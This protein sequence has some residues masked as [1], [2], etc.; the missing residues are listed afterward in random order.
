MQSKVMDGDVIIHQVPTL[1]NYSDVGTK[2]RPRSRLLFLLCGIV[3]EA[4]TAE[5]LGLEEY[6]NVAEQD[7]K[8]REISKLAKVLKRTTILMTV[9]GLGPVVAEGAES[10]R[11]AICNVP[12]QASRRSSAMSIL[13]CGL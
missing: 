2:S 9:Q 3:V 6:N 1:W 7:T 11:R 5:P 10:L 12:A 8:R 4:D 13:E